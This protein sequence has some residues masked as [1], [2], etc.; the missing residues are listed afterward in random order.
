MLVN[1]VESGEVSN[2]EYTGMVKKIKSAIDFYQGQFKKMNPGAS[3]GR[4]F[5][6]TVHEAIQHSK[7]NDA[8]E[9]EKVTC[10]SGCYGCCMQR[11]EISGDEAD[12]LVEEIKKRDLKIDLEKV[13]RLGSYDIRPNEWWKLPEAE[14]RCVFLGEDNNCM[15]YEWR[16]AVCRKYFVTSPAK[17]CHDPIV[18]NKVSVFMIHEAELISTSMFDLDRSCESMPVALKRRLD[19]IK[20]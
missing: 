10:K 3:R 2:A 20:T 12:V 16:P 5:L 14:K 15:V 7:K 6:R 8:K 11:V 1:R 4:M 19:K 13:S 18:G 9:H 17:E